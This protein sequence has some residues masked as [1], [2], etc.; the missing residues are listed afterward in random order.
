M[1]QITVTTA[2]LSALTGFLRGFLRLLRR[3]DP[4]AAHRPV[5]VFGSSASGRPLL[6]VGGKADIHQH[7][8]GTDLP[9]L[10]GELCRAGQDVGI[11]VRKGLPGE[12]PLLQVDHHQG[13]R[14]GVEC[15]GVGHPLNL[16]CKKAH[17][18]REA[19]E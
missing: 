13:G 14:R 3:L 12:D 15:E 7:D 16:C 5:D 6:L 1:A 4:G 8:G 18:A 17:E 2:Q 10:R 9:A 19:R 11:G